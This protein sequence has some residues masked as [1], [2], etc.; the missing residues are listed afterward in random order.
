[1]LQQMSGRA[2]LLL[3]TVMCS[4]H[5]LAQAGS[6]PA[7]YFDT[8]SSIRHSLPDSNQ[9]RHGE[10]ETLVPEGIWMLPSETRFLLWV[11][12]EQGRLNILEQLP[13]GDLALRQRIPVSIGKRGIGKSREGDQKTP[14]GT[15]RITSFLGDAAL[16]DFYGPGAFP[17]NY[18]NALDRRLDRTGHGIWLHGLPKGVGERPFLD[19]DGCVVIDNES[20]QQMQSLV[21]AGS[22]PVVLDNEEIRWVTMASQ[23]QQ[24]SALEQALEGWKDAW[25]R[26]DDADYEAWYAE[27]FSDAVRNRLAWV[28]YKR[29]VNASKS[30]VKLELSQLSMIVDPQQQ[31]LVTVRYF[32]RYASSNH[33]WQGWKEQ[34]WRRGSE[35]WQIIYEG[36]G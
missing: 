18:P 21:A 35:G 15:Y 11:E 27:D 16:D 17:L 4:S 1:M 32:Q 30:W 12:L 20:L 31:D 36:N 5:L 24:K 13:G 14:V 29:R 23:Q 28:D 34:I 9:P 2:A 25:E 6:K 33:D 19:S 8:S 3:A 26:L 10:D 22:T 7:V